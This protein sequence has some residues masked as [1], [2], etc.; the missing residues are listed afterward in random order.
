M[1]V[2]NVI[3]LYL[4]LTCV[5][6]NKYFF[7]YEILIALWNISRKEMLILLYILNAIE[8]VL[9]NLAANNRD[10]FKKIMIRNYF[11]I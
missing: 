1:V 6:C 4:L 3:P 9:S 11:I 7:N 2:F 5:L 8:F 10:S